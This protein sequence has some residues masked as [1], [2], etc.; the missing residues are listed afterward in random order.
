MR[1][2]KL[3]EKLIT[4]LKKEYREVHL[5]E[6]GSD[7][8][9]PSCNEWASLSGIYYKHDHS[10][11]DINGDDVF[12]WGCGQCGRVS[13]WNLDMAPFPVLVNEKGSPI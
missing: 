13:Y 9:C 10:W 4:F 6:R 5:K 8:K 12:V 2:K 11:V 1:Y 7:I 3:I